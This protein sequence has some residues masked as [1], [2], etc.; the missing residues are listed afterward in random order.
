M[1]QAEANFPIFV[2]R[3]K[4]ESGCDNNEQSGQRYLNCNKVMQTTIENCE[5]NNAS[6]Y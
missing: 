1:F 2:V 4:R 5:K 6:E 3:F